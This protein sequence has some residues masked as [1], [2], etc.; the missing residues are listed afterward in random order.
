MDD[1]WMFGCQKPGASS[2][3]PTPDADSISQEPDTA[4]TTGLGPMMHATGEG[5]NNGQL[6]TVD[7]QPSLFEGESL[8]PDRQAS[9]AR[10][11]TM[12]V[13]ALRSRISFANA[14]P[15]LHTEIATQWQQQQQPAP[16][17]DASNP[18]PEQHQLP[19]PQGKATAGSVELMGGTAAAV[20]A[21]VSDWLLQQ[22][23][24]ELQPSICSGGDSMV[25]AATAGA[26]QGEASGSSGTTNAKAVGM[27]VS[28]MLSAQLLSVC[29]QR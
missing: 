29:E 24:G 18:V 27:Q 5:S 12:S 22:V 26:K 7:R 25:D 8:A 13:P 21:S 15:P 3:D 28:N 10:P 2:S 16:T 14:L 19:Q 1:D 9:S 23:G 20:D 11:W 17:E 6:L 4:P